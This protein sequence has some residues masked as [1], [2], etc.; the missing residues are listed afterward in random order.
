MK[1][2]APAR[3]VSGSGP[4]CGRRRRV[5]QDIAGTAA[6]FLLLPVGSRCSFCDSLIAEQRHQASVI[7]SSSDPRFAKMLRLSASPLARFL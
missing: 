6:V 4:V 1:V 3:D 2:H 7:S 5:H